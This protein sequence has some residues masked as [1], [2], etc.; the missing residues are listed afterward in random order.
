MCRKKKR[1]DVTQ[2]GRIVVLRVGEQTATT[3]EKTVTLSAPPQVFEGR[4]FVPLRSLAEL[5]G[6]NVQWVAQAAHRR[7]SNEAG[8]RNFTDH[9]V[10]LRESGP[11]GHNSRFSRCDYCRSGHAVG[12]REK[13]RCQPD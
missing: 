5:F 1:I 13:C 6:Y 10:A 7:I 12:R 2:A 3:T 11:L 4:A 9:R 8:P